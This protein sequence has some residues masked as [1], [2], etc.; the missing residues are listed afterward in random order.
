MAITKVNNVFSGYALDDFDETK[1]YHRVLFKPG[2]SVQARELTQLQTALQKQIDYHGQY[3]FVD[4]ARVIG[5]KVSI[6]VEY[7]FIQIEDVFRSSISGG[8]VSYT[9][10]SYLDE[11]VG[12]TLT[13]QTSTLKA[14]VLQVITA[15]G[16]DAND[17]TKT[18]ILDSGTSDPI[19][20]YIKYIRSDAAGDADTAADTVFTAGEVLTQSGGSSTRYVKVGGLSAANA[21]ST[22]YVG[23]TPGGDSTNGG[24]SIS[25]AD[26]VGTGSVA[27][28]EEG[29][30]F[31]NGTFVYVAE[32]DLILNKYSATP[33]FLIGLSVTESI[34]TSTTDSSLVDNASGSPNEAAPGADR[35]KILA[36]LVKTEDDGTI[37]STFA[38][39]INLLRIKAGVVQ[40]NNADTSGNTELTARLARRTSEESGDYS[41]KPFRFDIREHLDDGAGNGGLFL[42]GSGGSAT[43][44]AVGVEPN[45]AY[46]QGFRYENIATKYLAIDKPRTHTSKKAVN[47]QLPLGN[48]VKATLS[49]VRGI[50]DVNNNTIATLQTGSD[51]ADGICH[52]TSITNLA[53]NNAGR[54]E[55]SVVKTEGDTGFTVT[56]G[57]NGSG[58]KIRITTDAALSTKIEILES[59]TGYDT[60]TQLTITDGDI[61]GG[62]AGDIVLSGAKKGIGTCR[63]RDLTYESDTLVRIY[64]YDIN[65]TGNQTSENSF[66]NVARIHQVDGTSNST[67]FAATLSTTG[68]LFGTENNSLVFPLPYSAIK[69]V[70]TTVKPIYQIRK[71][72]QADR[73]ATTHS[74]S[75]AATESFV[76]G[77]AYIAQH[78][79]APTLYT[80]ISYDSANDQ[81]DI[82]GLTDNTN[83]FQLIAT[84]QRSGATS[85]RKSKTYTTPAEATI[86][87]DGTNR[88]L[89]NKA[90]VKEILSLYNKDKRVSFATHGSTASTNGGSTI[91]MASAD[92][93]TIKVG[94]T[95]SLV[96]SEAAT[97]PPTVY[98]KVLSVNNSTDVITLDRTVATMPAVGKTLNFDVDVKANF[99]LDSGQRPNFYEEGALVP[100]GSQAAM[101]LAVKYAYYEHGAGD[102]FTADSYQ[103]GQYDTIPSFQSPGGGSISLRDA[104]DFRPLKATTGGI[105]LGSEFTTG[106]GARLTVMPKPDSNVIADMDVYLPRIDKIIINRSGQYSSIQGVPA[107]YPEIPSDIDD[108]MTV[109]TL[110]LDGY[111]YNI[112][113]QQIHPHEHKRYTMKDI[114]RIDDRVKTLE[115]YTSLNF[116]ENQA[117]NEFMADGTNGQ[118]FK[119]GIFV[120]SFKGHQNSFTSHP[121][122]QIAID[123]ERGLIRPHTN[124]QNLSYER[125]ANDTATSGTEPKNSTIVQNNSIY[126]L[127]F[128]HE[129]LI[130]QPYASY[131]EKVNPYNIF[132]WGGIC[133]L[134]PQSDEWK[135]T[136]HRPD[137]VLDNEGVFNSLM[138][139]INESG[140]LGTVW[141]EWET[142][143]T[144]TRT[145]GRAFIWH[146]ANIGRTWDLVDTERDGRRRTRTF[147]RGDIITSRQ[148]R[149]GLRNDVV[150]DTELETI[151]DRV[152]ET[153]FI[154]FI[155][156]RKIY[157]KAQLM[158]PN[159]KVY[160]FFN[161][162]SVANYV[163]EESFAEFSTRSNTATLYTDDTAHHAGASVLTTD[164]SGKVEGSFVIPN[165]STQ[166]FKT[167]VRQFRLSD[168]ATNDTNAETTFAEADYHAVGILETRERTILSTR[169][170]RVVTTELND[171]RTI[172]D[173]SG[174]E[175]RTEVDW[176]DPLAQTFLVDQSGGLFISKLDI[177]VAQEDSSIPLNVSIREVENGIPTQRIVPGTDQI[178]YP[179][180]ITPDASDGSEA[181]TVTFDYPVYLT[182]RS[183]Y[184]IVLISQ[185]DNYK[186]WVAE[187]GQN[188]VQNPTFRIN[189]QPYNGVFFTSQN[190]STWTPEQNKDLKF[191]LYR[192]KFTINGNTAART[193][194]FVNSAIQPSK[195][196]NNPFTYVSNSTHTVIRVNH[197][198][199]GMYCG[200]QAGDASHANKVTIAGFVDGDNGLA[201]SAVNAAHDVHDIE[202][203]SYCITVDNDAATT[204]GI[205]GGGNAI[206]AI[207]NIQFDALYPVNQSL[208]IDGTST[209]VKLSAFTG[210][211]VDG[212]DTVRSQ[213]MNYTKLSSQLDLEPNATNYFD[214][215]LVIASAA[216][217]AIKTTGSDFL[218]KSSA[219]SVTFTSTSD[220]LSPVLDGT[221]CSVYAI[222]NRTNDATGHEA[223][224]PTGESGL[225]NQSDNYG[226][227]AAGRTFVANTSPVGTSDANS[228]ITKIVTLA[229]AASVMKVHATVGR[230]PGSNVYLYYKALTADQVDVDFNT[231]DWIYASPSSAI[232]LTD[233][234]ET[235]EVDWDITPAKAFVYFAF[236]VVLTSTDSSTVPTLSG[237]R[238]IAAT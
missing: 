168:S 170:P 38:N 218:S 138:D 10:S 62:S 121:D 235:T 13:G 213:A 141:G 82:T 163:R 108:A 236:K 29:S 150:I 97:S 137:I 209:D 52:F 219:I 63:I 186:V 57:T 81:I 24:S 40:I 14:K 220:F 205:T 129:A 89:L 135:D 143:W 75:I 152:L 96:D 185:S 131:A 172:E 18:G 3:S 181:T 211:S 192:A 95:V 122:Y 86:E 19:T 20:V 149:T 144:G 134:S 104:I 83:H 112:K 11:L 206:T 233:T 177:F 59:G 88:A 45:T 107:E 148:S 161:G 37:N 155:R 2:V 139:G 16:V 164:D 53:S 119:N 110:E 109:A 182:E 115:Y 159:T 47:F 201:A 229:D 207:G 124:V 154:P 132:T 203:D 128:T 71:K 34:V 39:F 180:S 199:H 102:Y 230:P 6:D 237:F 106:T 193:A 91:N 15:G 171:N 90:D 58:L 212:A 208:I 232:P 151:G 198:N 93:S 184:A 74:F 66:A 146:G 26:A 231:I 32:Q 41:I 125:Y 36:T 162:T 78:N 188:D 179:G 101:T 176:V 194:N 228:Y 140:V 99:E 156:S 100:I 175:T 56:S 226:D 27:H 17:S 145:F 214:F 105:T 69:D 87:F 103:S 55:Q 23:T 136:E 210:K 50:P 197:P 118:R 120:D 111:M 25:A 4:G 221:R 51:A 30:Y 127:P 67:D 65:I 217:E 113:D 35:Y 92:I 31:I 174:L 48:Y 196:P 147:Q 225:N 1:N 46:V 73:S 7:D 85:T 178:V 22:E 153:S 160:A 12:T 157:F 227:T 54:T 142:N 61:L 191:T 123:R 195:L 8:S 204:T 173:R 215:P 43:K 234:I 98:G 5:G 94:M 169:R 117:A 238:A 79:N 64:L 133:E 165:T 9:S 33:S 187:Q 216:N 116:L 84:V 166:R 158:K 183:E 60:D 202:L 77:S 42:S 44:I 222:Q 72:F 126:T 189:K 68:T 130:T 167:G 70:A 80:N 224:L 76:S 28:I 114:G 200:P 49:T 223:T 190:A 21:T